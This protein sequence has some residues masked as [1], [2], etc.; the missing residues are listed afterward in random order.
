MLIKKYRKKKPGSVYIL[1]IPITKIFHTCKHGMKIRTTGSQHHSMSRDFHVFSHNC[2]I[3]QQ[4]LTVYKAERK[5]ILMIPIINV[6][7]IPCK[8]VTGKAHFF[9]VETN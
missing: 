8:N 2:D 1:K 7:S 6:L 4:I 9:K 3:T 5:K